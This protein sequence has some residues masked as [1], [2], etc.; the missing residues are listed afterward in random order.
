M[1]AFLCILAASAFTATAAVAAQPGLVEPTLHIA[2][3]GQAGPRVALT[4]DACMGKSDMRIIS[5]LVDNRLPATIFVT[6]RWLKH[7]PAVFKELM[8]HPDL[9]E[10]ENHGAMHVPAV[11][12]PGKVYGIATAG[13]PEAVAKEVEGGAAALVQ[14]GA[15]KPVWFRGST[16]RYSRSSIAQIRKLGYRVAGY[17]VNGD[18]GSLLGARSA[19][20]QIAG[21]K[22]GDV[23][24]AHIN[25]PGHAA[26]GGVV[27]GI[28]DL[29]ARG[30]SFVKLADVAAEGSDDTTKMPDTTGY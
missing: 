20:K 7:N 6:A 10:I 19:E 14:S 15:N 30:Y 26:G 18:G 21:A 2:P 27:K 1:R 24:I 28:L 22:D 23:V 17:S 13:S 29:K 9:F 25:Q 4:F 12:R 3:G 16:A 5:A 8:S 11:D